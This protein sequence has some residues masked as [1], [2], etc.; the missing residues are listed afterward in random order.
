MGSIYSVCV[1]FRLYNKK[2]LLYWQIIIFLFIKK[3]L[4]NNWFLVNIFD[5]A[6][7]TFLWIAHLVYETFFVSTWIWYFFRFEKVLENS[8]K[9][10]FFVICTGKSLSEALIFASTNPQYDERLSIELQVQYMKIPSSNLGRTCFEKRR[11]SDKD[12]PV[13]QIIFQ[14]WERLQI[15]VLQILWLKRKFSKSLVLKE[16]AWDVLL[17][18]VNN[19]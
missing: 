9:V 17:L 7:Q 4:C 11:A 16:K 8:F 2:T 15:L 5:V 1:G 12:L 3:I 14:H 10:L 13:N 18:Q 6:L 19:F